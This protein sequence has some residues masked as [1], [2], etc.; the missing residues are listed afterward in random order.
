M[1]THSPILMR[2]DLARVWINNIQV[3]RFWCDAGRDVC[4]PAM[5]V[6]IPQGVIVPGR[7][8][9]RIEV[10]GSEHAFLLFSILRRYGMVP[11]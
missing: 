6:N 4:F 8:S 2:I 7:N 9:I 1:A 5:R 10:Q 3:Y 11:E